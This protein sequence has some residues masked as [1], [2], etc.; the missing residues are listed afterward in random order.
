VRIRAGLTALCAAA[1]LSGVAIAGAAAPPGVDNAAIAGP[2]YPQQLSAFG[3]FMGPGTAHPAPAMIGYHLR[4]PLFSDY[5]EKHRLIYLPDGA[6]IETAADGALAL[7]VGSAIVKTF[8]Y[9]DGAGG[10]FRPIETRVLLHRADGWLALPY[11]WRADLSDADLK[12]AGT[13]VP[14][15]LTRPSG[16]P[17]TIGYAVPN[18]NQCKE[19]HN[20]A[21]AVLPIGPNVHNLVADNAAGNRRLVAAG[22]DDQASRWPV[23]DDPRSG[24]LDNRA[25]AYLHSNCSHCH[26]PDGSASNSGL[27]LRY[28]D[29]AGVSLGLYK[30]PVA[31]G[32]GS[33]ERSF[34]IV[35]GHPEASIM[36]YRMGSVEP[37]VAM[38]ELGRSLVHDEGLALISDWIAAMPQPADAKPAD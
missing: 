28:D 23:W 27:F 8:G 24:R 19:C 38:P 22:I 10:A 1:L 15:T 7:P 20:R 36:T 6:R 26:R 16:A 11:L 33:G 5:A 37:G 14:V 3:F 17:A 18:K 9:R 12:L 32:R 4:T 2:D 35:P 34:A 25:R 30:R 29:P 21:G 31:A 13:R